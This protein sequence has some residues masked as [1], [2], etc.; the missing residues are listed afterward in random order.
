MKSKE[1]FHKK[2]YAYDKEKDS[3]SP[4]L[5]VHVGT[6]ELKKPVIALADTGCSPCMNFCK[7][8]VDR[9]ELT[10]IQKMN[11]NPIPIGVADGHSINAD[12]YKAICE[13]DGEQKEIEVTVID[14]AKHFREGDGEKDKIQETIPLLGFGLLKEY[15]VIFRGKEKRIELYHC[16]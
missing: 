14:P 2:D 1:P 3:H 7:E 10:F 6:K 5:E 9:E 11:K 8:Y 12:K 4:L 15:D 16:E 13:I